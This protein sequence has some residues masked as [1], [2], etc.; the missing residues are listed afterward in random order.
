MGAGVSKSDFFISVGVGRMIA[1]VELR[2]AARLYR[3]ASLLSAGLGGWCPLGPTNLRVNM[4]LKMLN[5]SFNV[6][7]HRRCGLNRC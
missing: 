4:T 6:I 7:V 3:V 5:S 2:G 1:N